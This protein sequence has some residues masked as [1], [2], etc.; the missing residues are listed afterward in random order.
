MMKTT[1]L[2]SNSLKIIFGILSI[3]ILLTFESCTKK[4][5]FL[6]SPVVPAAEG[7]VQVK[8]DKNKNY[9]IDLDLI[10]LAAPERLTP[11]KKSYVVWM[12]NQQNSTINL[13]QIKS[14]TGFLSNSLK[15]SFKTVS[16]FK[17][18]KIFIT[19]EDDSDIKYPG[20]IVILTTDNF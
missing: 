10:R 2:K 1:Q 5:S 11:P 6:I 12:L 7:T 19:A 3:M 8:S 18:I 9:V 4:I 20:S 17:P 14:T 16:A 13:G 15:A